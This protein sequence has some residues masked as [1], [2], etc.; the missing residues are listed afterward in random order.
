VSGRAPGDLFRAA[1]PS[2]ERADNLMSPT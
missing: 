2:I 1:H